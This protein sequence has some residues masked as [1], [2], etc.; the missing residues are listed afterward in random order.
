MIP[1]IQT[2]HCLQKITLLLYFAKSSYVCT[3]LRL[4]LNER[5]TFRFKVLTEVIMKVALL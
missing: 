4:R 1:K 5:Y 3:M 2:V